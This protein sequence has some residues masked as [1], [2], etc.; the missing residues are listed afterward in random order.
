NLLFGTAPLG[1]STSSTFTSTSVTQIASSRTVTSS[2]TIP[3]SFLVQ[4]LTVAL[5]ITYPNDPDLEVFLTAPDGTSVELIKNA[6][7]A[8]SANSTGTILDDT[9]SASVQNAT[10]PFT[11][12]FQPLQPLS[13]FNGTNAAGTWTLSITDNGTAG[14]LGTLNSWSL[15]VQPP[16]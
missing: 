11:G 13:T 3:T 4:G 1:G 5:D 8:A 7:A 14:L 6:G 12:R 2:L 10:A 15:T 9:A 16:A